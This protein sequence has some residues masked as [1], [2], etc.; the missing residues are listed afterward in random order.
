[1]KG[2][3]SFWLAVAALSGLLCFCSQA[4]LAQVNTR[5]LLA[6]GAGVPNHP[7]FIF[8]RFRDLAMNSHKQIVFRTTLRSPR[9]ESQAIVRSVGVTFAVVAFG[10]LV[11]PLPHEVYDTFSAPSINNAGSVA[12]AATFKGGGD[13]TAAVIE[14]QGEN[15][16]LVAANGGAAGGGFAFKQFSAPVLGSNGEVLFGART[17]NFGSGLFLWTPQGMHQVALPAGFRLNPS[18]LLQPLFSSNNEAVFVRRGA[19]L[20]DA[21]E[22]LFRAVAIKNFQ[23]LDPPPAA[24]GTVQVLPAKP[25]QKPVQLLLVLLENGQAQ[26]AVL[27]G[28]PKQAVVAKRAPGMDSAD[29]V[30]FSAI[31]GQTAG[32]NSGSVIFAG[33][34]AKQEDGF[35][36]FCYRRGE[37]VRL[38]SQADFSLLVHNL[39]GRSIISL[40]SD[41][42]HVATFIAPVGTQPDANAIFVSYIP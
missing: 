7:G 30:L 6:S 10:G 34:P 38:T 5:V 8:G 35:G 23:Q 4:A 37:V 27:T 42:Q 9:M 15:S 24:S 40:A 19:S 18:D 39:N 3:K 21:C 12:F 14:V 29:S 20:E 16:R 28:D 25:A 22:Q 2:T 36:I 11:S 31:Q 33:Q 1:M 26:T 32:P 13:T 41:S 17:E